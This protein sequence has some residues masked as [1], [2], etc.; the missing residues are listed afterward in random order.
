MQAVPL[1]PKQSSGG[2][3]SAQHSTTM[4]AGIST[5]DPI[6]LP[7]SSYFSLPLLNLNQVLNHGQTLQCATRPVATSHS[8]ASSTAIP[9]LQLSGAVSARP[10]GSSAGSTTTR[11]LARQSGNT[12][13]PQQPA[14]SPCAAHHTATAPS[15]NW[16]T[17]LKSIDLAPFVQPVGPTVTIPRVPTD[18]FLLY[19]TDDLCSYIVEQTN[20]YAQQV[21]G[22]TWE[23]ATEEEFRAYFGF[24]ILMGLVEEPATEDNWHCDELHFSPIADGMSWKRFHDIHRFLHFTNNTTI[25][26]RG[27]P[28]YDRLSKVRPVMD[29]VQAKLHELYREEGR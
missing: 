21:I 26:P 28:G 24:Q 10:L 20:L 1:S 14:Q 8:S 5:P 7:L 18:T 11:P 16:S 15:D 13:P 22:T 2:E 12:R 17:N 3:Q 19:S 23:R 9:R 6:S 27:Q 4:A 25:V 29:K